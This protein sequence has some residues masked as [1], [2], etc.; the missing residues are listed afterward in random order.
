M[1]SI[2]DSKLCG[3]DLVEW[4]AGYTFCQLAKLMNRWMDLA[5]SLPELLLF[6]GKTI[7]TYYES[8]VA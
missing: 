1:Y 2:F 5:N 3:L 7:P 8:V 4:V 6:L